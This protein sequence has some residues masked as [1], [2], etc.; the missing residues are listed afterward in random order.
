MVS[1][2]ENVT[3]SDLPEYF[4]HLTRVFDSKGLLSIKDSSWVDEQRHDALDFE[5]LTRTLLEG[6]TR[7][8][9]MLSDGVIDRSI[10]SEFTAYPPSIRLI[11]FKS[12]LTRPFSPVRDLLPLLDKVMTHYERQGIFNFYLLRR[13]DFFDSRRLRFFED[14]PPLDRYN[15]YFEEV[16]PAGTLSRFKT[17]KDLAGGKTYPVDMGVVCMSLKQEHRRYGKDM[18]IQILPDTKEQYDLRL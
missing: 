17:Y 6:R 15:C 4:H 2:V 16:I 12:E 5:A 13:L 14:N 8:W 9:V 11:N 1:C 18:T 7:I 10:R 3:A